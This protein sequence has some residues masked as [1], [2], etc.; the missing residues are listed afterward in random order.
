MFF[1]GLSNFLQIIL[2]LVGATLQIL[3]SLFPPS[4]FRLVFDSQFSDLLSKINYFVP[5][6][7]FVAITEAWLV[8][9]AIYYAYSIY[10]RFLKAVQ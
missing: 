10:A 8:S 7:E 5:V 4:P 3:V 9:V 2:N 6:A 1:T